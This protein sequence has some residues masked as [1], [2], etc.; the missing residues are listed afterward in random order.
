MLT[1]NAEAEW[2]GNLAQGSERRAFDGPYF[3]Q[4]PI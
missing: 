1:H 2:K 3:V 4:V